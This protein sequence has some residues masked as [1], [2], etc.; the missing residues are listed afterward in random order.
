[1]S[2]GHVVALGG[3][4]AGMAPA[5]IGPKALGL[6]RLSALGM[7]VPPGFCITTG[8]YR[9]HL[10]A[11]GL[12]AAVEETLRACGGADVS[13]TDAPLA[14]LR[15]RI[16]EAPIAEDLAVE[17]ARCLAALPP[18]CAAVR[19]SSTA[20]DLPGHSCAG[21]HDSFLGVCGLDACL[22]A[23]RRCWASL[24]TTRAY[25][26]RRENGFDQ[27][28]CAMAV[29]VQSLVAA[30]AAGVMFTAHPVTGRT[31]SVTIEACFGL[32]DVLVSGA[33]TP[34]RFTVHKK[35]R[36]LTCFFI[37][38]KTTAHRAGDGGRVEKVAVDSAR[39]HAPSISARMA[40][41][42]AALAVR[43]ETAL[44]G[45][46]D[47]EWACARG[48][49][50]LLQAR[51]I[52]ARP[53]PRTWADRQVW[54]NLNLGEVAPD[55]LS[56]MTFSF[57]RPM[58]PRLFGGLFRILCA[59][60]GG[61]PFADRI[62][63]RLYFNVNTGMGLFR[64]LP[65]M[66]Q[67]DF[68]AFMGGAQAELYRR[69][70]LDLDEEDIPALGGS[71]LKVIARLPVS[72]AEIYAHGPAAGRRFVARF[73]AYN[74]R[75]AALDP[76]ALDTPRLVRELD[77][78][79]RF[80]GIDFD[81][82]TIVSSL[83]ALPLVYVMAARWLGDRHGALAGRLFTALGGMA[84][85]E[86]GLALWRMARMA[87]AH[88]DL[89]KTLL[90]HE[91]W[92]R[93]REAL[94]ALP[95]GG[96]FLAAWD[97]FMR[98]HGH[99]C[100]GELELHNPRWRE[101]PEY[102]LGLVR[103]YCACL[104]GADPEAHQRERAA[105]RRR[106]A[107]ACRARLRNPL[108]RA[109]FG[110]MLRLAQQGCVLRENVKNEAVRLTATARGMLCE[111]GGR[112]ERA[113][114]LAAR[115]DVFFLEKEEIAGA[116]CGAA[117]PRLREMIRIRRAQYEAMCAIEP[118]KVIVGVFDPARFTPDRVGA[119]ATALKGVSA[120]PGRATGK[121][122]VILKA[123]STH[124]ILP[125]EILV[126]PFTDPG[127]APYFLPAAAIVMDL[128]GILSHGSIVAR[129]YGIP[130]VVNVDYATRVIATGRTITVD[131]DRGW[132]YVHADGAEGGAQ[133]GRLAAKR[134]PLI[135]AGK[136]FD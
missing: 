60:P 74:E 111:L 31:T 51:P 8:A 135:D 64:H 115:D 133:P 10:A 108:K 112:L 82:L 39:A 24:W 121:A 71:L 43:V 3:V 30:E 116:A 94:A 6:A 57:L 123:D 50:Y 44:G 41:K 61:H 58:L 20:E 42:L 38:E 125:G 113:G 34:D 47:I 53:P 131:G 91:G 22:D 76:A 99:H 62:A 120:S 89:E 70:A 93:T 129:E 23:V 126:A 107:A 117:P 96:A 134:E 130:A 55:V 19:S 90:A 27:Q 59:D 110:A 97:A 105:A 56:P 119:A 81:L 12:E 4:A 92:P 67:Q 68:D 104:G 11:A 69:G 98:E 17:I 48:R 77:A 18:G 37:A 21:L 73:A 106:A 124:Q 45:A 79:L 5:A 2:A 16:I 83:C 49:P 127:W 33:V 122:R 13:R 101:M 52:T 66:R 14:H 114:V 75:L 103:S 25:H 87:R 29:I 72:L 109:V 136:L 86:A 78:V 40:R 95:G 7:P 85:A 15:A 32:G 35:S 102:C 118:P 1:M 132:V 100:R 65:A 84:D 80:K 28:G 26:Y 36:R 54:T 46:Q 88:P 9:A 128:G 63:G